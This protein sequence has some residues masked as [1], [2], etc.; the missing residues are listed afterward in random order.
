MRI[1]F[2]HNNFPAQ[3][4]HVATVLAR[5]PAHRVV[6]LTQSEQGDI[7]GV[8]KLL[9]E[10]ARQAHDSTHL[11]VKPFEKAVLDA[12]AVVRVLV[13]LKAKGFIPDLIYAHTGWGCGMFVK[14]VF[15]DT[16]VLLYCEWYTRSY[17]SDL[18]FDPKQQPSIDDLLRY[19]ASNAAMLL[20]LEACDAGIAPT[21]WQKSRFPKDCQHKINV[22]HDG[23]DTDY[24][25]P[26]TGAKL[27]LP[28][29][30]LSA[31]TE[32]VTFVARG[33]DT[34]RGFPQFIEAL[35]Q[36]QARRP[37]CHAVIV[38]EDR[39]AY[40]PKPPKGGSWKEYMLA[41]TPLDLSRVHFT[42]SLPYGFYKQVLQASSAHVY[43]TKPFVL[44]WSFLEA[45][46]CGCLMVASDTAPVREVLVDG[47]NGLLVD[48]FD[49]RAIADRLVQA[50]DLGTQAQTLRQAAR[51]TVVQRY[52]LTKLL[53]QQVDLLTKLI[54]T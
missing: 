21:E 46:A 25:K 39:I 11:Y 52:D 53:P 24:F 2:I 27:K 51:E 37:D 54:L 16:P 45:M 6:F 36:L 40:G 22:L 41:N 32:I 26:R 43:L 29:L 7:P 20:D 3:Y 10:P 5:N 50:L 44:S 47:V 31:V 48:F 49:T 18:D 17:G 28:D 38:A 23:I 19:R 12:Q 14:D 42:G 34:Y 1:V 9:F 4:R 15:P 30:D 35:A 13:Q 33:M 8:A